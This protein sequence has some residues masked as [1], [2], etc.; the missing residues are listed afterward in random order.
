MGRRS[1]KEN[2]SYLLNMLQSIKDEGYNF[3][4]YRSLIAYG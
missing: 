2:G 1:S 3:L 4:G